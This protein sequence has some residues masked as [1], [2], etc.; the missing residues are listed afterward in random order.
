MPEVDLKAAINAV[1]DVVQN[2]P[3]PLREFDQIYMKTGDMVM[4][5][6]FVAR[7]GQDKRL[8]FIGDGDSISV[9]TAYLSARSIV[10]YGPAHITVFDF[11]E[12]IVKAINRFA[13]AE[14]LPNL[15]AQLYNVLDPLPNTRRFDAFYTNPPWGASNAGASVNAFVQ[16]GIEATHYAGEGL[17]VIADDD[18]LPWPQEVLFNVQAYAS[19]RG[20]FVSEMKRKLHLYHLDDAPDLRSCNLTLK[21]RPGNASGPMSEQLP[22]DVREHFYGKDS[23]PRVKYVREL[24]RLD[25]GKANEAEYELELLGE[26]GESNDV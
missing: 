15:E 12:R 6:E 13:D 7:W 14:R 2:R 4:Q 23:A 3:R 20:Y 9:C 22:A 25:Y 19:A 17:V 10:S 8:A 5:S 24:A 18:D 16:R 11:D 21:A 26:D 1:S